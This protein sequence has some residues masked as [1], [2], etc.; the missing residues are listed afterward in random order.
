[1]KRW[2]PHPVLTPVLALVWL[3]LSNSVAPGHIL[4]G[5][6]LG[7]A[8]PRFTLPFWPDPVR[9][10]QPRVLL[11][12]CGVFL[13][14]V[15][16]ANLAVAKLILSGPSGLRPAFVTVPLALRGEL[17]IS[18]LANIICLTP[19]TVSAELT[20]DRSALIVHTLDT[21]DPEQLVAT[22]KTRYERPLQEVFEC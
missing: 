18:L 9:I 7:W 6:F 17:G 3:L 4:L 15:L 21:D 20:P 13:Y 1:M 12:L 14:D 16:I 11:R 22:I 8:I 2:L 5:L 10:R 19:G